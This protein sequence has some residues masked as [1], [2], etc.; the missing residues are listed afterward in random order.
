M[1]KSLLF[2]SFFC[3]YQSSGVG[4]GQERQ[5]GP[6][7]VNMQ[8][9]HVCLCACVLFV[10]MLIKTTL[11][12][13][14]TGTICSIFCTKG[15]WF[16]R[17]QVTGLPHIL[18]APTSPCRVAPINTTLALYTYFWCVFFLP[19][20]N[21]L[22]PL[23]LWCCVISNGAVMDCSSHCYQY[24]TLPCAHVKLLIS[25]QGC[26]GLNKFPHSPTKNT[27]TLSPTSLATP[28]NKWFTV[29]EILLLIPLH[30]YVLPDIFNLF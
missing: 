18:L 24:P 21:L 30:G 5:S 7:K 23:Y 11:G 13:P 19:K 2:I 8:H 1:C 25:I 22:G 16:F 26:L 12:C 17:G 14:L 15:C 10:V 9:V 4:T 20:I 29:A 6:K 27:S 3:R 28:Q